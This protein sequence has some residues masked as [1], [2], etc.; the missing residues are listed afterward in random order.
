MSDTKIAEV[1]EYIKNR[2]RLKS[3]EDATQEIKRRCDQLEDLYFQGGRRMLWTDIDRRILLILAESGAKQIQKPA[4]R[5]LKE[6]DDG[7]NK[8][9]K[10]S[11]WTGVIANLESFVEFCFKDMSFADFKK[12]CKP[13]MDKY[14]KEQVEIFAELLRLGSDICSD[15]GFPDKKI[16]P[17][18]FKERCILEALDTC[19]VLA[20]DK[21]KKVAKDRL[22][23]IAK[24]VQSLANAKEEVNS[25]FN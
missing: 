22:A 12:S 16:R 11:L 24:Y 25:G 6:F 20:P 7:L 18:D 14:D 5:D 4:L 17:E 13:F 15:N 3:R 8:T 2:M 1:A 23:L 19:E 10:K 21:L 9:G